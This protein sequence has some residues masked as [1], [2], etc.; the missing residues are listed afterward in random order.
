MVMVMETTEA[1]NS[2]SLFLFSIP[3]FYFFK[4]LVIQLYHEILKPS[5]PSCS[6]ALVA[7]VFS[8]HVTVARFWYSH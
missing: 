1:M 7:K 5:S 8:L 4:D 3:L 6:Q 2:V